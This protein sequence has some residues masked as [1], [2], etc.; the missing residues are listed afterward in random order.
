MIRFVTP[1]TKNPFTGGHLYNRHI[2]DA[3]KG[4]FADFTHVELPAEK[5]GPELA[6]DAKAVLLDSLFFAQVPTPTLEALAARACVMWLV[7]YLPDDDSTLPEAEREAFAGSVQRALALSTAF[8]ATSKA[9]ADRLV[10]RG[11]PADSVH[12]VPPGLSN[13][14][15]EAERSVPDVAPLRMLTVANLERR[16]G[17]LTMV[18]ALAGLGSSDVPAWT[19]DVVGDGTMAPDVADALKQR[20]D[21]LGLGDRVTLHGRQ[22]PEATFEHYRRAAFTVLLTEYEPYGMC[23]SESLSLGVPVV[24]SRISEIPRLVEDGVMGL[25]VE[26]GDVAGATAALRRMLTDAAFRESAGAAA[27]SSRHRFEGWT[28]T[29]MSLLS[30]LRAAAARARAP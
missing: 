18:E 10:E 26:P 20:I 12:W 9:M 14:F 30:L 25:L 7:H 16:K 29:A 6:K 1:P 3:L 5:V 22:T 8:I 17:H 13:R 23:I 11:C 28:R 21:A 15:L 27:W 19:W 2:N 24:A 4:P